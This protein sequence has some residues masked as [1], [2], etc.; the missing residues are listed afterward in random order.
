MSSKLTVFLFATAV[1]LLGGCA[2]TSAPTRAPADSEILTPDTIMK[3]PAAA[4]EEPNANTGIDISPQAVTSEKVPKP[5]IEVGTGKFFN[6][7]PGIRNAGG[8]GEGEVTFNFENQPIQ[9]VVKAIL[10]DM[11]QDNYSIAPNVGGNVTFSTAK[12]IKRSEALPV[13]EMLLS[14]TGNTLVREN[15]RY[16]VL[17]V[18]DAIPGS[19]R[20]PPRRRASTTAISCGSS[21]CSTSRRARWRNC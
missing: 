11:L 13:L 6:V 1:A 9:A 2:A 8:A 21:R 10:G 7:Q 3:S 5:E 14:W 19:S 12:P 18:K 4:P 20:R 17:P 15:G 16:T